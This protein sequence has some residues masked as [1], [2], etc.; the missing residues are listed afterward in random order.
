MYDLSTLQGRITWARDRALHMRGDELAEA[1]ARLPGPWR[2]DVQPYTVSRYERG[3]RPVSLEYL[4]AL[5]ELS[6]LS[7][8]WLV[9]G[10]G[11]RGTALD[12]IHRMQVALN[13]IREQ[14]R[15]GP[16]DVPPD[17]YERLDTDDHSGG[18][19]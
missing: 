2:H 19:A 15:T 8:D 18:S 13:Q 3:T 5:S 11:E 4:A 9:K 17:A 14:Y 10:E 7:L 16:Q 6:G 1:L 12:A